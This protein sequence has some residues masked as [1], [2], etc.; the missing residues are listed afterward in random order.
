[1]LANVSR[2]RHVVFDEDDAVG[3]CR[4]LLR[5]VARL[6]CRCLA[7]EANDA[8]S[9]AHLNALEVTDERVRPAQP[10]LDGTIRFRMSGL[11]LRQIGL[12]ER[13]RGEAA[14]CEESR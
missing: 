4:D 8:R 1:V 11:D 14:E 13:W 9:D 2:L 3:L 12:R 10:L 7:V 5:L 6:G